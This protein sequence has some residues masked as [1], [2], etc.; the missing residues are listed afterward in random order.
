MSEKIKASV[1]IV[2]FVLL[3]VFSAA[4]LAYALIEYMPEAKT[5]AIP[6]CAK[7][8]TEY[9]WSSWAG[10]N[11]ELGTDLEQALRLANGKPMHT[12]EKCID[13]R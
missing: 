10:H 6:T 7:Y 11:K 12:V 2:S 8:E 5:I 3:I 13:W 1:I 9:V 4:F